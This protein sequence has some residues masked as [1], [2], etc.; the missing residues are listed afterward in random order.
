MAVSGGDR[1]AAAGQRLLAPYT[2]CDGCSGRYQAAFRA[3]GPAWGRRHAARTCGADPGTAAR[4]SATIPVPTS[5]GTQR[6]KAEALGLG[7]LYYRQDSLWLLSRGSSL[8]R[9][10]FGGVLHG[11]A[12]AAAG[13]S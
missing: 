9:A 7:D 11:F 10:F 8:R 2:P 5:K 3:A 6:L 1:A 12:R 4:R 13:G